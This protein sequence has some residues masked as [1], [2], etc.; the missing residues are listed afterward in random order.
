MKYKEYTIEVADDQDREI[1]IADLGDLSF[2]SFAEEDRLLK[3][4][5]AEQAERENRP[6]FARCTTE[7]P[8]RG[9]ARSGL[10]CGLGVE[11]RADR[12][13][14]MLSDPG[15]VSS[16]ESGM[17]LRHSDHAQ[18]GIRHRTPCDDLPDGRRDH[19]SESFR[20]LRA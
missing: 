13:S 19:A 2:D 7:L 15:S 4:Y 20:T 6:F 18:D 3:A 16:E 8:G 9:V 11:F 17:S 10:E 12:R 1:L 5:I 14:G